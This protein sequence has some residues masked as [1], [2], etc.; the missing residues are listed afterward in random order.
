MNAGSVLFHYVC[1]RHGLVAAFSV[2]EDATRH[3]V[4]CPKC[5]KGAELWLGSERQ[6]RDMM[7]SGRVTRRRAG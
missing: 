1:Q 3:S 6:R 4:M 7:L 2:Y 5:G